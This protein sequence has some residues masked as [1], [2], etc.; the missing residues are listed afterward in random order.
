MKT[1]Q[2]RPLTKVYSDI[3]LIFPFILNAY[4]AE[5]CLQSKRFARVQQQDKRSYMPLWQGGP[6]AAVEQLFILRLHV[7]V[8]FTC[9]GNTKDSLPG[10]Y[11]LLG[12]KILLLAG[13]NKVMQQWLLSTMA[14]V[15]CCHSA[16]AHF[17]STPEPLIAFSNCSCQHL[18]QQKR[19]KPSVI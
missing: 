12:R 13:P 9:C 19:V 1:W 17:P 3:C 15:R 4:N 5:N 10:F 2:L 7:N 18:S 8:V 6:E 11:G 14:D 16:S